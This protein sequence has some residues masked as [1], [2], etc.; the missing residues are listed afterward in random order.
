MRRPDLESLRRRLETCREIC[1]DLVSLTESGDLTCNR[2][3]TTCNGHVTYRSPNQGGLPTRP[4]DLP[5]GPIECVCREF[6]DE[7]AP[8]SYMSVTFQ[9]HASFAF[10]YRT[11][12]LRLPAEQWR[13]TCSSCTAA[14]R[15]TVTVAQRVTVTFLPAC[16]AME[17][18]LQLFAGLAE[19][20]YRQKTG[21]PTPCTLHPTPY[22]LHPAPCT[23]HPS[24]YL[25][26]LHPIS[27]TLTPKM[28][29]FNPKPAQGRSSSLALGGNGVRG[30]GFARYLGLV[31][32]HG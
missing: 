24:P 26:T 14:K 16:R 3:V 29:N 27:H 20:A 32:V 5:L 19:D 8:S 25:D 30:K 10:P 4:R 12:A 1:D 15:V 6:A 23:L 17:E 7:S 28:L 31:R 18:D 22:T 11:S 2:H 21:L 13:R 9:L